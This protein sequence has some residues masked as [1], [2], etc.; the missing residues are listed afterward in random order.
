MTGPAHSDV[1]VVGGGPAGTALASALAR[2]GLDVRLVAPHPPTPF[3]ATYGVWLDDLPGW[4]TD[5]TA[6]VW[7][8]VRV[9][10]DDHPRPLHR[11]YAL[12]D[13]AALMEGLLARAGAGLCWTVGTV[14]SVTPTAGGHHVHGAAGE[15]WSARLVVDAAGHGGALTPTTY[16]GGA[17]LQ[18]AWGLTAT[19]DRP[20]IA[21]GS[22]VWMDYRPAGPP[23]GEPTFLYAMHLGGDRY[24]VEETTLIARPAVSRRV[25]EARLHARLDAAGTPPREVHSTEWVAFPM[26]GAAPAPGPLLAFGAAAGLVHPISGF[27][28]AAA[29]R[30]SESVADAVHAAFQR[31]ADPARAGWDVLWPPARRAAREVHLLGVHALLG[32][33]GAALPA[34]F[35][36]FFRLPPEQWRA[37]LGPD[38]PAGTLS[39]TMLRLF[40]DAPA[41]VRGPL[42]RAA[43]GQPAVSVR[44]LTA[45]WHAAAP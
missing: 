44:A 27:Q 23:G 42:A 13:N 7:T 36:A 28:V 4:A 9:Y 5:M 35:N 32:L 19:F 26:N 20:P 33:P 24:F 30:L 1:V 6:Q 12:L 8:D 10:T 21:P 18:T 15:C 3:P 11:P 43:L 34:F 40:L 2:R 22:M 29:L 39:R 45:A 31:G 41:A 37:F 25:L 38:T 16:P 14:R 17:A